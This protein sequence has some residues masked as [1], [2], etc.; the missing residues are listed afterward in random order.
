MFKLRPTHCAVTKSDWE[1]DKSNFTCKIQT[2]VYHCIQDE[3]NRSG[4]ICIQP[5][6][7]KPHYCPEFNTGARALDTVPC[8]V[9]KGCPN[10]RFWSNDVYQYPVCLNK[11]HGNGKKFSVHGEYS[12]H[13]FWIVVP[14]LL[15][16]AVLASATTYFVRRWKRKRLMKDDESGHL[17]LRR[18]ENNE[19]FHKTAAFHEAKQ[20]LEKD[21]QFLVLS[22]MWGSGKTKTAQEV[23]RS[24]TEKSPTII[25]DLEKFDWEEQ[26]QALVFDEAIPEDLSDREKKILKDKINTWREKVPIGEE[27]K[28]IIFTSVE[29][30]KSTFTY[31]T[32]SDVDLKLINLNDRLT[33]GDRTQ[34]LS[35]HFDF[36]CPNKDF[37]E[38]ENLAIKDKH[39]S[40][41]YPEICV[42]FCRC[43][44]FQK[45]KNADFSK[46]PLHFLKSYLKK[47]YD[48]QEKKFLMLVYMS[49]NQMEIDVENPDEKLS[50]ILKI[51]KLAQNELQSGKNIKKA[52][53]EKS[54]D[55]ISLLSEEFVDKIPN[56]TKYRL[57]HDVIKKMTLIVFGT[58]H[59]EQ[60]L[61]LSTPNDMD[62]WIKQNSKFTRVTDSFGSDIKPSLFIDGEKWSS[63]IKKLNEYR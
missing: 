14:I 41:G 34:I 36:L 28:F 6:W 47:M 1:K 53:H 21:G 4:E 33:K 5:V 12:L 9:T 22:G 10:V 7:V 61:D 32:S 62:G 56:S 20:F 55:I 51:S 40:L 38:I 60:L 31:I 29:D 11:T 54:E 25:T 15:G 26:N 57:Q 39:G 19:P 44:D 24:V 13:W 17:L 48:S 3:R 45:E 58:Y 49:L 43:D 46:M 18:N 2:N 50:R 35:S 59:F 23:F 37:S 52:G 42:L 63:Y 27:K 30:R 16:I 8:N